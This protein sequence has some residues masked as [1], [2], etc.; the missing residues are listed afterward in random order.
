MRLSVAWHSCHILWTSRWSQT[1]CCNNHLSS[2]SEVPARRSSPEQFERPVTLST[3]PAFQTSC[4]NTHLTS[5]S[6][7]LSYYPSIEQ[8]QKDIE[9][10]LLLLLILLLLLPLRLLVSENL[11]CF[12]SKLTFEIWI[13]FRHYMPWLGGE[14]SYWKVH[15]KF[16]NKK[17]KE[18]GHVTVL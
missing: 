12:N 6:E 13:C 5:S 3:S 17:Y 9:L 10:L 2:K 14:S 16:Q 11:V 15:L 18:R 1:S 8:F 4:H 7:A